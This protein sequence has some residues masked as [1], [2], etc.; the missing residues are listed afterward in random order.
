MNRHQFPLA[1]IGLGSNLEQPLQQVKE[2]LEA[3][4]QLPDSQLLAHSG[5]YR[6]DPV[7][8]PGQPDYIN[9]VALI[10]TALDPHTLLD[11]MQRIENAHQRV[12]K[13]RWGPR[14]LDLDLLLF[15][16][17]VIQTERLSVPHPYLHE[18][19]FVLYPL[20]EISPAL[21][22]PGK[23]PLFSLLSQCPMAS[24]S[25]LPSSHWQASESSD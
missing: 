8:P 16:Q 24:L 13:E 14:T 12:R 9:A 17:E 5:L 3:L 19:S 1:W 25:R 2:A 23:G 20:A 10:A 22:I 6:S 15:G 7:G 18:R 11:E 21:E 4:R